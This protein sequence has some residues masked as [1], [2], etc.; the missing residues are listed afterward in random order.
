MD[1]NSNKRHAGRSQDSNRVYDRPIYS[2]PISKSTNWTSTIADMADFVMVDKSMQKKLT[3]AC[4]RGDIDVAERLIQL[5]ADPNYSNPE[6][7]LRPSIYYASRHGHYCLLRRLIE[8]YRCNAYYTTPRGTTLL[9]L[10]CLHGHEDIVK[11]LTSP[12]IGLD[13]S[14][15]NKLGSTPLHLA[16]VGGHSSVMQFLIENLHCDPQCL[17]LE[18]APLHTA[19][20]KGHLGILRYLI[21]VHHCDPFRP[22]NMKET[23][24]HLAAQHGYIDIVKYLIN[25]RGCD[26]MAQDV[27]KNTPLHSAAQQNHPDIVRYL[28]LEVKCNVLVYNH[29]GYTPLHLACKYSRVGVVKVLLEEAK[30]AVN[31]KGPAN[32]TPIQLAYNHEVVKLLI[33]HGANPREAQVNIFPEMPC[34]QL[35]DTIIRIMVVGDPNSGKTTL[36]E[37]LKNSSVAPK[38]FLGG[39]MTSSRVSPVEPFTAGI[40]PHEIMRGAELGHVL[41][42]DFAGHKEY[43]T[44]HSVVIESTSLSTGPIFVVVVDLS[45]E[46]EKIKMRLHY[47]INFIEVSRPSFVSKPHL[48]VVG[49]HLDCIARTPG[50][51]LKLKN[52]E[53]FSREQTQNTSLHFAGF[54]PINCQRQATQG[55][56][57]RILSKSCSSLRVHVQDDSL[58]HAFSVFLFAIFRG[59]VMCTVREV[60]EVIQQSDSPFPIATDKLCK[61]CECLGGQVNIMFIRNKNKLEES[62]IVLDVST[63]LGKIQGVMFA[64]QGFKSIVLTPRTEL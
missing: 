18:E 9:H 55:D 61:L 33:R 47:W 4:I 17:E 63:L 21:D 36:V 43:Y 19:C 38:K 53:K 28:V 39:L 6:G 13:P 11:Y 27:F 40:I 58:C 32:Q 1:L 48:V 37:A 15:K 59:R 51:D 45:K 41:I 14:A 52:I 34:Y 30:M 16:C 12:S 54:F 5:G 60:A 2:P 26:P 23:P 3:D 64:P 22:T 7:T 62:T 49:S 10:A 31:I 50:K 8:R 35:E 29:D 20:I 46:E 57:R 42:F 25:D 24:L 44:S 56:L